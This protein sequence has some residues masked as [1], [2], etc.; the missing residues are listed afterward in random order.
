MLIGIVGVLFPIAIGFPVFSTL[1]SI[2]WGNE[3][4][5]ITFAL[6]LSVAGSITAISVVA[7]TLNDLEI[8]KTPKGSLA[9]SSCAINDI[10]GWFLFT[11]VISLVTPHSMSIPEIVDIHSEKKNTTKLSEN[12]EDSTQEV[13]HHDYQLFT[14]NDLPNSLAA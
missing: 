9:L 10:F 4:N 6:F 12:Q 3:A 1:D 11:V 7:R 2:Y 14:S 8:S 5:V 13:R